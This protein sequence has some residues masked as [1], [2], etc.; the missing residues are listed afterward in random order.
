MLSCRG[1][2]K[3][4]RRKSQNASNIKEEEHTRKVFINSI[5]H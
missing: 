4:A 5:I 2:I 1:V 3:K